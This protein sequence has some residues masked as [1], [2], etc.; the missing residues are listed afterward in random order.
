[1]GS[2]QAAPPDVRDHRP[3]YGAA[4]PGGLERPPPGRY[5]G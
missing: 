1:M 3:D 5:A 2:K 4:P